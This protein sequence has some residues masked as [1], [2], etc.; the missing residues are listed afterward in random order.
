MLGFPIT[1]NIWPWSGPRD[2]SSYKNTSFVSAHE[3]TSCCGNV[4]SQ[5]FEDSGVNPSHLRIVN[6]TVTID[7]MQGGTLEHSCFCVFQT[8]VYQA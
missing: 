4:E 6:V 8:A 1:H 2:T 7:A 3:N 5:M